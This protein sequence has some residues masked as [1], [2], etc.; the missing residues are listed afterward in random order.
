M[1]MEIVKNEAKHANI[2]QIMKSLDLLRNVN[3]FLNV[4]GH[5][6]CSRRLTNSYCHLNKIIFGKRVNIYKDDEEVFIQ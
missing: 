6:T 3:V 2:S 1:V 4:N 5:K